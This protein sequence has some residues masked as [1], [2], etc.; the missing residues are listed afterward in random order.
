[1][2]YNFLEQCWKNLLVFTQ[3][4]FVHMLIF[5]NGVK[6]NLSIQN[7]LAIQWITSIREILN[8]RNSRIELE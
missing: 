2:T 7:E 6:P 8:K 3:W 1:M 4:F 5:N